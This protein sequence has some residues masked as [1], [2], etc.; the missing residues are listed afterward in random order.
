MPA[1][2]WS[3]RLRLRSGLVWLHLRRPVASAVLTPATATDGTALAVEVGSRNLTL[4]LRRR[5]SDPGSG[6]VG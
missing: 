5:G 6:S 4:H 3:Q 2:L 1:L